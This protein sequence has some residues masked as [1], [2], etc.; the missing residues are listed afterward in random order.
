MSSNEM[1][2]GRLNGGISH[3]RSYL[4]IGIINAIAVVQGEDAMSTDRDVRGLEPTPDFVH[5]SQGHVNEVIP[6]IGL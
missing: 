4:P 1:S 6:L 5:Y 2:T 3:E